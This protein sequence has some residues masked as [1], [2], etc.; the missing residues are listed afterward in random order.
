MNNP[1]SNNHLAICKTSA[2]TYKHAYTY[3]HVYTHIHKHTHTHT[4]A[5][6]HIHNCTRIKVQTHSSL[7]THSRL[8]KC[9]HTHT[10]THTHT[11]SSNAAVP[12][13]RWPQSPCGE[14]RARFHSWLY[15]RSGSPLRFHPSGPR[16]QTPVIVCVHVLT[17]HN[18]THG[19]MK[20]AVA[21]FGFI[22]AGQGSGHLWLF[23][24]MF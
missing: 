11:K 7:K 10:H 19:C 6:T 4:Y 17:L 12:T 21:L 24:C 9:T 5:H 8:R 22:Q 3:M 20:G 18:F 15:E 16:Q 14:R 1:G 23:A 13:F 2:L